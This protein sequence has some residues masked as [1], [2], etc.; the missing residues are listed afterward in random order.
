MTRQF[1]PWPKI[2][3]LKRGMAIT[4]KIDGTNASIAIFDNRV[5]DREHGS[6]IAHLPLLTVGDYDVYAGSRNRWL[7]RET[8]N[9][10]FANW[11]YDNI[12]SLIA[13]GVGKHFGEWWGSGIQRG[14]GLPKGE[15]RFSLFN[16]SRWLDYRAGIDPAGGQEI[17]PV[18]CHVVP[19]LKLW[20]FDTNVI[21][22][23]METLRVHGSYAAPFM[24][25]EGIVIYHAASR[26][27]YK[28]TFEKDEGKGE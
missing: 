23:V 9:F 7:T 17:A 3:R 27:I 21:D 20:D 25:P 1:E 6:R 22:E 24:N 2:P 16:S 11:V 8:D 19:L 13:L 15:K 26:T 28:R 5:P 12:D 18:A 10:G 14:Y 4:E